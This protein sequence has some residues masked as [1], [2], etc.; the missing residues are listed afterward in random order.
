MC[1]DTQRRDLS[2]FKNGCILMSMKFDVAILS[3][4]IYLLCAHV[5]GLR[6]CVRAFIQGKSLEASA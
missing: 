6:P 4:S 1:A 5:D 3:F 2:C